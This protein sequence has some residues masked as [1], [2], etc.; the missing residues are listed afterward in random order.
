MDESWR[1]RC[2]SAFNILEGMSEKDPDHRGSEPPARNLGLSKADLG[3]SVLKAGLSFV[4]FAG[5]VLTELVNDFIPGQRTDRLVAFV[6]ALD[7]RLT[8]VTKEAF[9]ARAR[10][11]EGADLV[12]DGLWMAARAFSDERRK[13]IANMLV[14][15]LTAEELKY[16]ESK[17]LLQLLNQLQDPEIVMLRY[18]YLLTQG[19]PQM[20]AFYD[21]SKV[22]G[23]Q[24]I[25]LAASVCLR[26]AP[27]KADALQAAAEG[28][29]EGGVAGRAGNSAPQADHKRCTQLQG[30][31]QL[32]S[33]TRRDRVSGVYRPKSRRPVGEAQLVNAIRDPAY[34]R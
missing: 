3:A 14:T 7:A 33:L 24:P 13:A 15:T 29:R 19:D 21:L 20:D 1:L 17:N 28:A 34:N 2:A 5:P 16:A 11:S 32:F 23:P 27:V 31:V 30:R 22:R 25:A 26:D 4:P 8:E 18:F 12:E 9:A 10:T 6:Q